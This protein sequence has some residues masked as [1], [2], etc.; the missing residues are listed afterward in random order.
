[1]QRT[2]FIAVRVKGLSQWRARPNF[3][4][5]MLK[6]YAISNQSLERDRAATITT[7]KYFLASLGYMG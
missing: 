2:L 5:N 6:K 1:M 4:Y 7:L 3:F